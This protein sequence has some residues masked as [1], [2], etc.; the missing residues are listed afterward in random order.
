MRY[1]QLEYLLTFWIYSDGQVLAI[2]I[3]LNTDDI[4]FYQ[5]VHQICVIVLLIVCSCMH[6]FLTKF[7]V[8]YLH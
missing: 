6:F 4:L 3:A 5:H 8:L 2:L 1:E 7:L